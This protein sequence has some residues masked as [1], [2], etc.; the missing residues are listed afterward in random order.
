M[1]SPEQ[2]RA[3]EAPGSVAVVAGAGTGKTHMLSQRYVHHLEV[4][5]FTPLQVVAVTFTEQAAAELRARI[6]ATVQQAHAA[7]RDWLAELE[8][9]Q[10]S[11]IHALAAR[12]CRDHPGPAG[13]PADFG[14]LDDVE[15]QVWQAESLNAVLATLPHAHLE[16]FGYSALRRVL[17][18]LLRDPISSEEALSCDPASWQAHLTEAREAALGALTSAPEWREASACLREHSGPE[19]DKAEDARRAARAALEH[20]AVGDV[21]SAKSHMDQVD[22]RGGSAKR[23]SGDSLARVKDALKYVR[24][25]FRQALSEGLIAL[26]LSDIDARFKALL[27]IIRECFDSVRQQLAAL[28]RRE[29]VLDFADLEVHALR[30]LEHPEVRAH[31]AERWRA[32]LVDEFQ[33]TNVVQGRLLQALAAHARLTIVGDEKQSIYGFRRADV[34]VFRHYRDAIT[35]AGGEEVVLSRSF[36]THSALLKT[37]NDTFAP[38]FHAQHQALSAER[39]EAP[40][41]A[42]H[43]SLHV[44]AK[45]RGNTKA[46]RRLVEVHALAEL[47]KSMLGQLTVFDKGSGAHRPAE[48]RD[49]AVL[50]RTW[51]PLDMYSEVL[52]A[53]GIPAIHTGGGNLLATREAKDA[54]ALLRFL[55]DSHDDLALAAVLRSPFFAVS[56][57]ELY[58]FADALG[59]DEAWWSRLEQHESADDTLQHA[60]QVLS[61][62]LSVRHVRAPSELLALADTLTGYTSVL[63]NLPGAVRREAD[64]RGFTGFVRTLETSRDLFSVVR[65]LRRLARAE[66]EVP[67]LAVDAG[68]AVTLTTIHGAKG[69]EWPIVV[70]ADLDTRAP[71]ISPDVLADPQLGVACPLMGEDGETQEPALYTLLKQRQRQR[72]AEE[73]QRLYYVALTRARDRLVLSAAGDKGGALELLVPALSA[74]GVSPEVVPFEPERARYPSVAPVATSTDVITNDLWRAPVSA[75][76]ASADQILPKIPQQTPAKPEPKGSWDEVCALIA[77]FDDTWLPLAR[78]LAEQGVPAPFED[79]VFVELMLDGQVSSATAILQWTPGNNRV[80]IV[81]EGTP[82]ANYDALVINTTPEADAVALAEQLTS[83]LKGSA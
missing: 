43:L 6:R 24:D 71:A 17:T 70:L 3:V 12:I 72:E 21:T 49:M 46:A 63:A 64:W 78:S 1:L 51:A 22:L 16:S 59:Q 39:T 15:G 36:R 27:P 35:E 82:K 4:D 31:Y 81:E 66:A 32:L 79:D 19:G 20:L 10:I 29:R 37:I 56:D 18:G 50:T 55:S 77:E 53:L 30:A 61:M 2:R 54:W 75:L 33:D 9:A 5:G 48:K 11:T 23:W 25:S 28:K 42:P 57:S 38:L 44:V 13:V 40:H 14:V 74:A 68:D 60:V 58:A 7:R 45:E 62:V 73:Q 52:P 26:E 69:L 8:A 41:A 47:L 65:T 80:A 83:C 34:S 67:R 76:A